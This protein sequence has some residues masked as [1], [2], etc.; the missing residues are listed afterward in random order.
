MPRPGAEASAPGAILVMIF[1]NKKNADVRELVKSS[2]L[3]H[4]AFI[5]D[6]NGRWASSRGL[7]REAGHSAGAKNFK[8][9]MRYCRDIGIRYATVYAF[10]TE[11]WKRPEREVRALMRLLD[12]EIDV[13]KEEN[14][15]EYLFIGDKTAIEPAIRARMDE[16]EKMTVGRPFRLNIAFNYGGRAEIVHAVNS[17]IAEGVSAVTEEDISRSV[18]TNG[19]PD[20]DIIV[21][22]GAE[23]RISN[24]LMWQS[25]YSELYFSDKMWPDFSKSDIDRVVE[26]FS[27]R[28]RR[29]GGL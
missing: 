6:G 14:D 21:R 26:E 27:R 25:A 4:V 17:L 1:K 12:S 28:K 3:I 5:M 11:N 16:L 22:T 19:C 18:F 13:A 15:V 23:F 10:S 29:F 24:F 9:L 2:G 7:P 20:P 8:T